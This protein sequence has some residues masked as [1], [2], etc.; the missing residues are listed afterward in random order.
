MPHGFDEWQGFL[1]L[2]L[3]PSEDS[4][5][6]ISHCRKQDEID[7]GELNVAFAE[8]R[9]P[10]CHWWDLGIPKS[11][12]PGADMYPHGPWPPKQSIRDVGWN[13]EAQQQNLRQAAWEFD[14]SWAN[15]DST[16]ACVYLRLLSALKSLH[17]NPHAYKSSF[18]NS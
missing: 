5:C 6:T 13:P 15:M 17:T 1:G 2:S 18:S 16:E 12:A 7:E 11:S 9:C 4:S 3:V 10:I 14:W 8:K